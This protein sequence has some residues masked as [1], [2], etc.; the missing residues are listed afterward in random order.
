MSAIADLKKLLRPYDSYLAELRKHA[1]LMYGQRE[2]A[3]QIASFLA[4]NGIGGDGYFADSGFDGQPAAPTF[5][6][7]VNRFGLL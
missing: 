4:R 7:V 3:G 1:R 2:Y 6:D 5:D